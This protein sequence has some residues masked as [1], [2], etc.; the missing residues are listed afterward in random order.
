M[1]RYTWSERRHRQPHYGPRTRILKCAGKHLA[2][3]QQC[4]RSGEKADKWFWYGHGVNTADSPDYLEKV[5]ADAVAHF[6]S[7][8]STQEAR[9]G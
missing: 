4:A 1:A 5:E 8:P 6:K 7:R 3:A 2:T 9:R